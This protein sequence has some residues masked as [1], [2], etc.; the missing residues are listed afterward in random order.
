MTLTCVEVT[1]S[2]ISACDPQDGVAVEPKV[3]T[4]PGHPCHNCMRT[5]ADMG[6][7]QGGQGQMG[8]GGQG[9]MGQGGQGQGGQGQMGQGQGGQGQGQDQDRT[10]NMYGGLKVQQTNENGV[11]RNCEYW[12]Y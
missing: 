2:F 11:C 8:Q 3:C 12:P 4:A 5:V 6:Q 9:Q 10:G 1:Y 7:G